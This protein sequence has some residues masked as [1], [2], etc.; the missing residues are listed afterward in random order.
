[1]NAIQPTSNRRPVAALALV[2]L[3]LTAISPAYADDDPVDLSGTWRVDYVTT[4]TIKI[5]VIDDFQTVN[6]AVLVAEIEQDDETID[7]VTRVCSLEIDSD[8][9]LVRSKAPPEFGENLPEVQRSG[10]LRQRNGEWELQIAPK[11]QTLGVNLDDPENDDLPD[12]DDDPR[13]Y[14]HEGDGNPGGTIVIEGAI[15]GEIYVIQK[16]W[17]QWRG[18]IRSQNRIEGIL[19]WETQQ[20]VVGATHRILR[21]QPRATP[22]PDQKKNLFRMTRV[23]SEPPC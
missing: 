10:R 11:W 23:R 17:D 12:N 21:R 19:R 15:D 4:T 7:M 16:S 5:P 3:W 20:S 1:M 18:R 6:R 2:F 9:P 22:H 13:V 8:M 14:D